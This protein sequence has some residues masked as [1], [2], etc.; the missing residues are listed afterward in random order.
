MRRRRPDARQVGVALAALGGVL[1]AV[2]V[3]DQY[4]VRQRRRSL[5]AE[6]ATGETYDPGSASRAGGTPEHELPW[7][8]RR[9][10]EHAIDP[11]RPLARR[12]ELTMTGEFRFGDRWCPFEAAE[13]LA[14]RRGF[15]WEPTVHLGPGVWFSGA[16]FY[17]DGVGGQRFFL[18]GFVPVVRADGP[19]VDRSSAGRFLAESVWL[20]TSLLPEMGAEWEPVGENRAQVTLPAADEPLTITVGEDGALRSV[21][22]MRFDAETGERRPFG[23]LVESER[24]VAGM[25]IPWALEVGWGVGTDAFEPFFRAALQTAA[26]A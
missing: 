8:A 1:G 22:T 3:H 14:A 13:V 15:V 9:Y 16:D 23:A 4:D 17:V 19:A 24:S 21:R 11:G 20:P 18:D 6:R 10:L 12:V 25:T 7:P 26:F 2:R 5:E